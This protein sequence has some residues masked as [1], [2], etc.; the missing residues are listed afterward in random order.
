MIKIFRE[1]KYTIDPVTKTHIPAV[2]KTGEPVYNEHWHARITDHRG[3]RLYLTLSKNKAQAQREADMIANRERE[4]R[5]G[6]RPPPSSD[7]RAATRS[8]IQVLEEYFAWGRTHGGRKGKPW[9]ASHERNKRTILQWW[10]EALDV[11]ELGDLN[12]CLP[13]VEKALRDVKQTGRPGS[14]PGRKEKPLSG[15][16]LQAIAC[17]LKSL[18]NWCVTRKYLAGNP[19]DGLANF[20]I[21]PETIRRAMT[22]EEL[23]R[24]LE[25]ASLYMRMLLEVALCT[26]LRLGE[27]HSLTTDHFDPV[28]MT[29]RVDADH[30]KNRTLRHQRLP[31]RLVKPLTEFI[32]SGAAIALYKRYYSRRDCTRIIPE[33]PLLFVPSHAARSLAQI[34]ERAGV[35]W[36]TTEGKI[37]FHALRVAYI[38]LLIDSGANPKTTQELARHKT[39]D[40][41]MNVYGRAKAPHIVD[42]VEAVGEMILPTSKDEAPFFEYALHV[43]GQ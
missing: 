26:G 27:L 38:N 28:G 11:K 25:T 8:F 30:D 1:P 42:A 29:L 40:M 37:D 16:T 3:R 5:L 13:V 22:V 14:T 9:S 35:A 43:V 10:G 6:L 18:F 4:I 41:T 33:N 20:D 24:L 36:V 7:K 39:L 23:L 32:E 34:A 31:A 12:D 21:T 15:K 19:L 17:E 2:D